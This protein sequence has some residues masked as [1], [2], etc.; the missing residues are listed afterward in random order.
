M[1]INLI[2]CSILLLFVVASPIYT[3][4]CPVVEKKGT[5]GSISGGVSTGCNKEVFKLNF[6]Q[7]MAVKLTW[8]SFNVGGDMPYCTDGNVK[9]FIG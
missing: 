2:L 8:N 9:V 4:D 7:E 5:S 3:Y 1:D 6:G